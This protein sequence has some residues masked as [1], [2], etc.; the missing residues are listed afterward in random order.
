MRSQHPVFQTV[1][2]HL[3]QRWQ[4]LIVVVV[5]VVIIVINM[6]ILLKGKNFPFMLKVFAKKTRTLMKLSGRG[7]MRKG[8]ERQF[9]WSSSDF[10]K[11]DKFNSLNF[12]LTNSSPQLLI[13]SQKSS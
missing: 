10:S 5:V 6:N 2:T 11:I 13:K 12:T 8:A 3:S 4:R 7:G 9:Q 1:S